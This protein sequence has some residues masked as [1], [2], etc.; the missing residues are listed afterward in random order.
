MRLVFQVS[1]LQ[2]YRN[3]KSTVFHDM[4]FILKVPLERSRD[5]KSTEF[6]QMRIVLLVSS[7]QGYRN[8]NPSYFTMRGSS[9]M[10]YPWSDHDT[11]AA[12]SQG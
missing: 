9:F 3:E 2:G 8:E 1:S 6:P 4:R 7:L 10:Y 5:E 12:D 11:T